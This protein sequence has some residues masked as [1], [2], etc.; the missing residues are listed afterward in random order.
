M[1]I[2]YGLVPTDRAQ[3]ILDRIGAK[4]K[5][6]G[7]TRFDLGLPGNLVPVAKNDYA[8]KAPGSS[9]REDGRDG[10]EVFEN[11]GATAAYAYFY[12]QA[13]Y[14]NG[15][16]EEADRILFPM[17]K[18]YAAGGFQ[19]GVGKGGEWRR[20]DG[21]PSGYEGLLADMYYT[22]MALFTGHYGIGFGPEGFRLEPWSPLR[23]KR[24][25]L[26]LKYMGRIV[27]RSPLACAGV[28]GAPLAN[29]GKGRLMEPAGPGTHQRGLCDSC[30]NAGGLGEWAA[31]LESQ[32]GTKTQQRRFWG[33]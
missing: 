26:G 29:E 13:L 6:V 2:T 7:Y 17:L 23:G 21:R 30:R 1:A 9:Q 27:R 32:D 10:F 5:E 12:L 22:Q 15:R 18:T 3:A 28:L 8:P 25:P 33:L 16:R 11:G 14:Q 20:W 4:I 19:N 24:V 31:P